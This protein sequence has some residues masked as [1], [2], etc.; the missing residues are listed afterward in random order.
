MAQVVE[1]KIIN[2]GTIEDDGQRSPDVAPV[3]GRLVLA[4]EDEISRPL[5]R[6]AFVLLK[7]DSRD[8]NRGEAP[9]L[10]L[11]GTVGDW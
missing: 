9:C 4:V 8:P 3:K 7:H 6:R 2:L 11:F 1:M 10:G 5:P